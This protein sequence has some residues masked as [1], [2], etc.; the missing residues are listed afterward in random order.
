MMADDNLS[1]CT[2]CN[3]MTKSVVIN[4]F[5]TE[6]GK[7]GHDKSLSDIYLKE[8]KEADK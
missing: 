5:K 6:C 3:C 4:R 7:C 8:K 2:V 1:Y